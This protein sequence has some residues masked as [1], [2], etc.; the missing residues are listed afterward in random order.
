MWILVDSDD[1]RSVPRETRCASRVAVSAAS[2]RTG[3]TT[4]DDVRCAIRILS[5]CI[6]CSWLAWA[7]PQEQANF[8]DKARAAVRELVFHERSGW[9]QF[10]ILTKESS[11]F[12]AS[13]PLRYI[14]LCVDD[15]P[16]DQLLNGFDRG[17]GTF[18]PDH[19]RR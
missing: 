7:T 13:R 2:T 18:G 19:V 11:Y 4:G 16:V 3:D 12:K 8:Q 9:D 14:A 15:K 17:V 10:Q 6:E 1:Q 5:I